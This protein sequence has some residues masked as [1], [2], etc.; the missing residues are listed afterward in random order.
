VKE[1][2]QQTQH[3]NNPGSAVTRR[4]RLAHLSE[5]S[6]VCVRARASA[7]F[8]DG[9]GAHLRLCVHTTASPRTSP[10]SDNKPPESFLPHPQNQKTNNK[11]EKQQNKPRYLMIETP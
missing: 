8:C 5:L 3:A 7:R 11:K 6:D 10:P 4:P 2:W 9:T 1:A